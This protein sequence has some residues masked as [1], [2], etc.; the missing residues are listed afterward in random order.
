[1]S[2]LFQPLRLIPVPM[3][4]I[5]LATVLD[6]V[7]SRNKDLLEHIAALEGKVF[8]L[9]VSD[10]NRDFYLGFRHGRIWVH[11]EHSGKAD[12]RIE[13]TSEG[14]ARLCFSGEDADDLVFK[15][16]LKPSGDSEAMLRFKRLLKEANIDWERE[17]RGAFGD[18]FGSR[19]VKAAKA[20]VGVQKTIADTGREA[21]A[22]WARRMDLPNNERFQKW[23]AGIEE[24]ERRIKRTERR[25]KRLESHLTEK[26]RGSL[27][28]KGK[29][30]QDLK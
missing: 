8:H 13:A 21:I 30:G 20:L 29:R 17:L 5:V 11:P 14:F 12:V 4:A 7:F 15:Q 6:L 19:V 22:S 1:M 24:V 9:H 28:A 18:F 23:Q 16:V 10:L 26:E 27:P 3:Q 2:I 25:L